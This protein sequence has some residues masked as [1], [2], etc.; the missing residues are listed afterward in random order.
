M[1]GMMRHTTG[2]WGA[3]PTELHPPTIYFAQIA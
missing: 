2:R 1:G 3:A